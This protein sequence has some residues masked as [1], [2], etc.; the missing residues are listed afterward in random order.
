MT[1]SKLVLSAA[2]GV[3]GAGLDVDEVFSTHMY[4]GNDVP[5]AIENGIALGNAGDGGSAFFP[6]TSGDSVDVTASS[7]FLFDGDFTIEFFY[8]ANL[9]A[10]WNDV[11]GYGTS[12]N[13]YLEVRNNGQIST[14]GF[15]SSLSTNSGVVDNG[16]WNHIALVRSGSDTHIY[17]NGNKE[18]SSTEAG[19]IGSSSQ[20]I[21]IGNSGENFTGY[22]SNFRIVK[23]TAV[24]SGSSYTV[25]TSVLTAITNTKLLLFQGDT[26]F[27]D[28]S[29]TNKT[30]TK[31]GSVSPYASDFGPFTGSSG[32]G[33]LVW[34][35]ERTGNEGHRLIDTVRGS[36]KMLRSDA[37]G[38][39]YTIDGGF[40]DFTSTGFILQSDQGWSINSSNEDYVS[41]TFRKAKKFFDVVTYSGNGSHGRT[42][43][44]NLGSVPGMILIK[45]RNSSDAW[46]VFHRSQPN[47]YAALNSTGTF[48][49]DGGNIFGDP[50]DGTATA[51]TSTNF[52]VANDAS[53]NG[54]GSTYVAYLFAHNDG[55]GGFGPSGDADIIKCGSYTGNGNDNGPTVNVGFEPQWLLIKGG[56]NDNWFMVDAVR[57][58]HVGTVGDPHLL[59]NDSAVETDENRLELT[60]TGFKLTKNHGDT[61]GNGDTH[62]YMAIR[63]GPLNEPE[64]A[65]KVF[66]VSGA[67]NS[68]AGDNVIPTG[69]NV[70][71][72]I[73]TTTNA[74]AK[75][76]LSRFLGREYHQA[77]GNNALSDGGSGVK[78]FDDLSNHI[79]LN[80]NWWSSNSSLITWSW[81]RAPSY[82]DMVTYS[83]TGSAR[84]VTHGLG[85]VPEMIWVKR[86]D[87]TGSWMVY[88]KGINGGTNPEQYVIYLEDPQGADQSSA[89]WNNTAPT[90]SVFT[91][92][93]NNGVNNSSGSYIAYLFAS[94]NGVSKL[95]SY[96]GNDTG[97]NID[98]GF[99]SGARFV[100]IKCSS[101]ADSSWMLFDTT[102]GIVSGTDPFMALESTE[103]QSYAFNGGGSILNYSNSNLDLI[104]PYSSGFAVVGG[105][106]MVNSNGKQYI[107]YAIA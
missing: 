1:A 28:N 93:N 17:C 86:R 84:T 61:N 7:D 15:G 85:A 106:R 5:Q 73:N 36:T 107:F 91:V 62:I 81:K 76:V 19:S 59:A 4:K 30:I 98:C 9:T 23:G 92:K 42:V 20:F 82:F 87:T 72:N 11:F 13:F 102:Q 55:D 71:M 58:I 90:S 67:A 43:S 54:S 70:D 80:S 99:S 88:H 27:V 60:S 35:K 56:V 31:N 49:T 21:R 16:V 68:T 57:G 53:V 24:Y 52:T 47:K 45:R 6:S 104:D 32:E 78:Y 44:H 12:T 37:A 39:D 103:A 83:G 33:G 25:P 69:F 46:R 22:L 96:T 66:N 10:T 64:D 14:G 38:G 50:G 97:Q 94:V 41:W 48:G 77:N 105:T 51:P 29:G 101:H 79:N 3:G 40:K 8:H 75:Y 95:G 26:P 63:R 89:V 34:I 65:T 100:L 18:D 74:Q 2:S